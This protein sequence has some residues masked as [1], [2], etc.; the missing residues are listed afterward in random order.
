MGAGDVQKAV[1]ASANAGTHSVVVQCANWKIIP[2]ENMIADF[3]RKNRKIH[4]YMKER[5][6]HRARVLHT[7]RVC[8]WDRR[9]GAV[10]GVAKE[11]ITS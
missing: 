1:E 9:P 7:Q 10:L 4:A 2:L 6:G 3:R 5:S 8:R 11:L